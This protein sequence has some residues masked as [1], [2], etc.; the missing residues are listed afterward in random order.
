M[1]P[2]PAAMNPVTLYIYLYQYTITHVVRWEYMIYSDQLQDAVI[3]RPW[4]AAL[5]WQGGASTLL[6]TLGSLSESAAGCQT[7]REH[8]IITA[9]AHR[10]LLNGGNPLVKSDVS[11]AP[12]S[13]VRALEQWE[14]ED[15]PQ[16]TGTRMAGGTGAVN[17]KIY[18]PSTHPR[19][20]ADRDR[21]SLNQPSGTERGITGGI[22]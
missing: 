10:G 9:L 1:D 15:E 22:P 20:G 7:S 6:T 3:L 21:C 18:Y 4:N 17:N 2:H 19:E 5:Y 11:M 13:S 14:S 8:I 12:L 16:G